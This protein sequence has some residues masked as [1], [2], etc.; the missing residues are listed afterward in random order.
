MN[1]A[2]PPGR[3]TTPIRGATPLRRGPRIR[4]ASARPSPIRAG[5]ALAVLAGAAAIYGLVG[6][7]AFG[8]GTLDLEGQ[9][10]T[11]R[12]AIETAIDLPDGTNLFGVST[13][14]IESALEA[15]PAIQEASVSVAL[16]ETLVVRIE[17]RVPILVWQVGERRFLADRAGWLLAELGG[18]AVETPAGLPTIVDQRTAARRLRVGTTIDPVDLQAATQLASLRA[19]D[20]GSTAASLAVRVTDE[21]GFVV[22]ARP[23]GWTAVFGFYTASLRTTDIIPGQVRLLRSL[24]AG[25]EATVERVILA[26]EDDGTFTERPTPVP[27]PSPA[28]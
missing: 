15:L 11:A 10:W 7:S 25:R 28:P 1:R 18:P 9:R 2:R 6:S 20:V 22:A 8:F 26:S 14:P 24:L 27:S 17:E 3:R 16:P 13:E 5:A 4:R 12:S 21:S 23:E 19:A